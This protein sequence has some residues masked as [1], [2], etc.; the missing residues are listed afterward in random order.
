MKRIAYLAAV[1]MTLA[2]TK[3]FTSIQA[4]IYRRL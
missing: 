4:L 2:S 1:A 3:A